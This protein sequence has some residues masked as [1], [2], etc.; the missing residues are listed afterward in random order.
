MKTIKTLGVATAL[1]CLTTTAWA[2]KVVNCIEKEKKVQGGGEPNLI[3]TCTWKNFKSVQTG[4]SYKFQYYY[5]YKLFKLVN[6]KYVAI[7]NA[8]LFNENLNYLIE[9][10]NQRLKMDFEQHL[11]E[12]ESSTCFEGVSTPEVTIGDAGT[13]FDNIGITF[14]SEQIDFSIPYGLMGACRGLD[15]TIISFS[16]DSMEPYFAQ[17]NAS[18]FNFDKIK[19]TLKKDNLAEATNI[20]QWIKK[21]MSIDEKSICTEK[22][23]QYVADVPDELSIE[24]EPV[25]GSTER[26]FLSKWRNEFDMKRIPPVHAFELGNGGCEKNHAKAIQYLGSIDNAFYFNATIFCDNNQ[27]DLYT[28]KLILKI[29]NENGEYKIDNVMSQAYSYLF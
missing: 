20:T 1:M 17:N 27:A 12:P 2:Q 14:N 24:H 9:V 7:K 16:L 11:K 4:E 21:S 13:P 5:S 28:N 8:Q 29:I 26:E 10:L 3:K 25:K 18:N 15:G 19:L 22:C 23:A 6:N